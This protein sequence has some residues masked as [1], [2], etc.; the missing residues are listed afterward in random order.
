LFAVTVPKKG[1]VCAL[2]IL[3]KREIFKGELDLLGE[4]VSFGEELEPF[5]VEDEILRLACHGGF[6][7]CCCLLQA[8]FATVVFDLLFSEELLQ[9][10]LECG[11]SGQGQR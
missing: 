4:F 10:L 5:E 7:Y 2:S 1:V 11:C 6:F 9:A 8:F 3:I